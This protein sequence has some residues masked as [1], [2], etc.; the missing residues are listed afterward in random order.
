M[1]KLTG[2]RCSSER[3]AFVLEDLGEG[4]LIA[5][6]AAELRPGDRGLPAGPEASPEELDA[7]LR[8][9]AEAYGDDEDGRFASYQDA[10]RR[11]F[12]DPA[13]HERAGYPSRRALEAVL[14]A[15]EH[16]DLASFQAA[17][18]HRPWLELARQAMERH[19]M[20]RRAASLERGVREQ[21]A[22]AGGFQA[23][24]DGIRGRAESV[25]GRWDPEG[26]RPPPELAAAWAKAGPGARSGR[27]EDFT[28][29]ELRSLLGFLERDCK[30]LSDDDLRGMALDGGLVP[31]W[32]GAPGKARLACEYAGTAW[33]ERQA[34]RQCRRAMRMTYKQ[35]SRYVSGA[36]RD[37]LT[38]EEE[39]AEL[40]EVNPVYAASGR[41][42]RE[43]VSW[44]GGAAR[45]M[46]PNKGRR[47]DSQRQLAPEGSA[48]KR[49]TSM[50]LKFGDAFTGFV[51]SFPGTPRLTAVHK[52]SGGARNVW[53]L[54][55]P[56]TGE[57]FINA[58]LCKLADKAARGESVDPA[59]IE[60]AASTVAHE[61]FHAME[62]RDEG[63]ARTG[64][65]N[66]STAEHTLDE[67]GT[68][69]L[70]RLHTDR[71][72]KAMGLWDPARQGSLREQQRDGSYGK[73][74]ETVCALAAAAAGEL[75][76]Q[77]LRGGGYAQP[78]ALSGKAQ[79]M[80][81]EAHNT[82]G[83]WGRMRW[84]AERI[85][86][87]LPEDGRDRGQHA[88]D[89]VAGVLKECKSRRYQWRT[90]QVAEADG[91]KRR[92]Y[93]K[94]ESISERLADMLAEAV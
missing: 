77:K 60:D 84:L 26:Y 91:W 23:V 92:E 10:V 17:S 30:H 36:V 22:A 31:A 33:S 11:S 73:E 52:G 80:L 86:A 55:R 57:V 66:K 79:G 40:A 75:D 87:R 27:L 85:E 56:S 37:T 53:G 13:W 69:A 61:L 41:T 93:V 35:L 46:L 38:D 89:L 65:R 32:K 83:V 16:T 8:E 4:E 54:Y 29:A 51:S 64:T 62:G 45:Q 67:G 19:D 9:I 76:L 50:E 88:Q 7:Y 15:A 90:R 21:A 70:A 48:S 94:P 20:H 47:P 24:L 44:E 39:H 43:I 78:E 68:E 5:E 59:R 12:E 63:N 71:M 49:V 1:G 72:A 82:K 28:R 42:P 18:A 74:V 14:A 3:G 25:R 58:S 6:V 34:E 81:L 2:S